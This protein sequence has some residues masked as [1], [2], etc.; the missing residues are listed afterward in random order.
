MLAQMGWRVAPM[1]LKLDNFKGSERSIPPWLLSSIVL[2]R[3]RNLLRCLGRRFEIVYEDFDAPRGEVHWNEYASRS[4][5]TGRFSSCLAVFQ[6]C[7][8]TKN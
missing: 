7:G 6:T 4:M 3:I 5:A 2:L 1:P 8:E